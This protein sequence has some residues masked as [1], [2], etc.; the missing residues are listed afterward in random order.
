MRRFQAPYVTEKGSRRVGEIVNET[1]VVA[2]LTGCLSVYYQKANAIVEFPEFPAP[3]GGW[4]MISEHEDT[5]ATVVRGKVVRRN[6]TPEIVPPEPVVEVVPE[7]VVEIAPE[8]VVEVAPEPVVEAVAE[9]AVEAP[10][11][12][13]VV[14]AP[15]D[16]VTETITSADVG[17]VESVLGADP[18]AAPVEDDEEHFDSTN[19]APDEEPE[20]KKPSKKSK[21][22]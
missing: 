4:R 22:K 9:A 10:A 5:P 2:D 20:K 11:E 6:E 18:V 8:P 12:P 19:P 7:P 16:R 17:T 21:K 14:E 15:S 13:A 1:L 3:R